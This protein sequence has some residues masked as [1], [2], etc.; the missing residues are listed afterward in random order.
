MKIRIAECLPYNTSNSMMPT[1]HSFF[2]QFAT[3]RLLGEAF[4]NIDFKD[5]P[6]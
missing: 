6:G 4:E 3:G 2:A 5:F 1:G